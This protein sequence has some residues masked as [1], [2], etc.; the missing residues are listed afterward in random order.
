M[1]HDV[2]GLTTWHSKNGKCGKRIGNKSYVYAD[3]NTIDHELHDI[4][5]MIVIKMM[6]SSSKHSMIGYANDV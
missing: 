6:D 1:R 3:L 4:V 2:N 5:C